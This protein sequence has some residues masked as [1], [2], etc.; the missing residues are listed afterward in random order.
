VFTAPD[1]TKFPYAGWVPTANGRLSFRHV[2]ESR[3]PT[4]SRS[5]N[6]AC[7]TRRIILA[8]QRRPLSDAL[9]SHAVHFVCGIE[10]SF[11]FVLTA[12]SIG[13]PGDT[14]E[15]IGKIYI[16]KSK[17]DWRS[18]GE[19]IVRQRLIDLSKLANSLEVD[20]ENKANCL[21]SE[22]L[23]GLQ[24]TADIEISYHLFRT[25]EAYFAEPIFRDP[26]LLSASLNFAE[27]TSGLNFNKWMADQAYFFLRDITHVHQHHSPSSD[28]ILILQERDDDMDFS[29]RRRI[30]FSLHHYII[31]SKR[32]SDSA[33]LFQASG[34]LAYCESFQA[35]C[36]E[37]T[38]NQF[39]VPKFNND[40]L[41][42]SINSRVQE[43]TTKATEQFAESSMRVTK[44]ANTR[45]F[46][47]TF[48]AIITALIVMLVQPMIETGKFPKLHG[49]AVALVEN[50][51]GVFGLIILGL[52]TVWAYTARDWQVRTRFGRDVLEAS[53]Y[54]RL[55]FASLFLVAA[56]LVVW[57][58]VY[59][60]K[61]ALSDLWDTIKDFWGALVLT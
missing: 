51:R 46:A 40:A 34:V 37:S 43:I 39:V 42:Q 24:K 35:I 17:L 38:S 11:W 8:Y 58:A 56:A 25:G 21:F 57:G 15:L 59:F 13:V 31:R 1:K 20:R 4:E 36:L 14:D 48:A 49:L 60:G 27:T 2:G 16:Y 41:R 61:T 12:E 10:G 18:V 30:I 54:R 6:L 55:L 7:K 47:L 52:I 53:N 44:A 33:S 19:P 26:H 5:A 45:I 23:D 32:F 22:A 29:W 9:F 3:N 28:T 50:A